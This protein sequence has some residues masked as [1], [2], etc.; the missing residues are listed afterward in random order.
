MFEAA[1]L[2]AKEMSSSVNWMSRVKT[3]LFLLTR[4]IGAS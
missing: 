1:G 2:K 3:D 4:G